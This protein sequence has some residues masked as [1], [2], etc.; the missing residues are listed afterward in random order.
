MPRIAL[1]CLCLLVGACSFDADYSGGTYY[2]SG[3]ARC[4]SGLECRGDLPG[5]PECREPRRDAAIDALD[6]DAMPDARQAL[7]TCGD[8]GVL[9]IAGDTVTGSTANRTNM[10]A[11]LCSGSMMFGFDAVY[12]LDVAAGKQVTLN[13]AASHAATAYIVQPCVSNMGCVG[14]TYA[15]PNSPATITV[16]AGGP[17][18]IVVDSGLAAAA[19]MYTLDVIVN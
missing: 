2:C 15:F 17:P 10:V 14:N 16:L 19:G 7:L 1:V 8:P 5:K 13:V 6:D 3:G 9:P 12:R 4:P 18:F 11:P